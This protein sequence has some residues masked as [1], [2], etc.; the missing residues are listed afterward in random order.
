LA[1]RWRKVEA[2]RNHRDPNSRLPYIW[3]RSAEPIRAS[4]AKGDGFM[5]R[6]AILALIVAALGA[7][8]SSGG[9]ASLNASYR[10]PGNC[11]YSY[12]Y[13]NTGGGLCLGRQWH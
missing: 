9:S 8:Q 1:R 10:E 7:C 12:D 3:L 2:G 5:N 13:S 11:S 4:A 6:T